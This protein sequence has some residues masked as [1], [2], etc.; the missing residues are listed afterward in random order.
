MACFARSCWQTQGLSEMIHSYSQVSPMLAFLGL[1]S[2]LLLTPKLITWYSLQKAARDSCL[3]RRQIHLRY[4][5]FDCNVSSSGL[6]ACV[7]SR[8]ILVQDELGNTSQ[9]VSEFNAI[10]LSC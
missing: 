4:F 9:L 6:C 8:K 5:G 3:L 1:Y 7:S 2:I 10:N